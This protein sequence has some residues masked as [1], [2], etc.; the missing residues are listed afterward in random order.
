MKITKSHIDKLQYNGKDAFYWDSDLKGFGVKVTK[1]KKTFIVQARVN[2][3]SI[4][5]N[6]ANVGVFTPEQARKQA[7]VLLG[8]MAKGVDINAETKREKVKSVTLKAVYDDYKTI[9][10][11]SRKTIYDY[12]RAMETTFKDWNDKEITKINRNM[13]EKRFKETTEQSPAVANLHFRL[14][15]ALFN[16]AAE[17]YCID[18]EPIIPSNPC[19]R[20][21]ILKLW[22]RIERKNTYIKPTQMEAFFKSLNIAEADVKQVQQAKRQCIICLFT[23]A[24]DQE[25]ATLKRK[26]LNFDDN[27]IKFEE[28]KNHHTHILPMGD[29]LGKYLKDLCNELAPD[30]Y[31]FPAN[32]K[33][34]HLRDHRKAIKQIA[35]DCGIDFSLHDLRRTFA[36]IANNHIAGMTQYTLKKLLNHAE[37]DVTTG[38]IQ[39]EPEQLRKPMQ[40]IEDFI[41]IQAGIKEEETNIR[42]GKPPLCFGRE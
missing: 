1:N 3:R 36:S 29:W 23:G 42:G 33:S 14:L 20:L 13:I 4:R 10:N 7:Q 17:K 8:E 28:T 5:K 16:F 27:T 24:R 26:H 35:A 34:G 25:T 31:L 11:L 37:D 22:N 18:G 12:D 41:L 32:N 30:D 40:E 38:Y 9:R 39:F 6:I 15:R 21:K 19:D 2:G